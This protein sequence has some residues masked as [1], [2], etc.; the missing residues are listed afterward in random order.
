VFGYVTALLAFV[1][2]IMRC[3]LAYLNHRVKKIKEAYWET[4][5]TIPQEKLDLLSNEERNFYIEYRKINTTYQSTFP[6]ELD[7]TKDLD[8]PRSL[9]VE[10][11]VQVECGSI[12]NA[13]GDVIKLDRG[14]TEYV[15]KSDVEH[16]IR[17]GHVVPTDGY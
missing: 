17:L 13:D 3:I 7:L 6:I 11:R 1:K 10:I 4:A 16:L 9:F 12:V 14:A 15:R 2:R 8:P 5:G